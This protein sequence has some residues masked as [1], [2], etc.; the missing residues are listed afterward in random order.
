MLSNTGESGLHPSLLLS[1]PVSVPGMG[2]LILIDAVIHSAAALSD[3]DDSE[4]G[5]VC[6][7]VTQLNIKFRSMAPILFSKF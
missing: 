6:A 1:D 3:A 2:S 4:K 5:Q 7:N